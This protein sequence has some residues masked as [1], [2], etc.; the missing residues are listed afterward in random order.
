M[1]ESCSLQI[2]YPDPKVAK[3]IQI[4]RIWIRGTLRGTDLKDGSGSWKADGLL[5]QPV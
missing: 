1:D 3:N 5:H 2:N 4:L